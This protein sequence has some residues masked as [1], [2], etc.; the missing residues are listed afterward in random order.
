MSSKITDKE[1]Y[2]HFRTRSNTLDEKP[3]D[4]LWNSITE[5]MDSQSASRGKAKMTFL[6][7]LS[8]LGI[9]II[10]YMIVPQ[11]SNHL[12]QP[13]NSSKQNV[14][15]TD[16]IN[17]SKTHKTDTTEPE[18]NTQQITEKETSAS[19]STSNIPIKNKTR[20]DTNEAI[21]LKPFAIHLTPK[22]QLDSLKGT[23]FQTALDTVKPSGIKVATQKYKGRILVQ[24]KERITQTQFD[25]LVN[26]SFKTYQQHYNSLLIVRAPGLK[27]YR[28][29]IT[30]YTKKASTDTVKTKYVRF[31]PIKN[32]QI[33]TLTENKPLIKSEDNKLDIQPYSLD[34]FETFLQDIN[35]NIVFPENIPA[36]VYKVY[37]NFVVNTDGSVS[38]IKVIKKAGYGL[39]EAVIKAAEKAKAKLQPIGTDTIPDKL[40]FV[41]PITITIQ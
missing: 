25:S 4:A 32:K 9:G 20:K 17:S 3:G 35:E 13:H 18:I 41:I 1:L 37:T 14:V 7:L 16:T 39:D 10:I 22:I 29:R 8:V 11:K 34:G 24:V 5:K 28:E 12:P 31:M 21:V 2:N 26:T 40:N 15:I 27:P 23:A 33:D 6:I 30:K 38:D 36:G 19:I